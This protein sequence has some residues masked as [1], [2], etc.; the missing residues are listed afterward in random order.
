MRLLG[1]CLTLAALLICCPSTTA[2]TMSLPGEGIGGVL[3]PGFPPLEPFAAASTASLRVYRS[4]LG[5]RQLVLFVSGPVGACGADDEAM[6]T[7]QLE[8][9]A[10]G[11]TRRAD[12][13]VR[14]D[15]LDDSTHL[16]REARFTTTTPG[17]TDRGVLRAYVSR[18]CPSRVV[19]VTA[20]QR[21]GTADPAQDAELRAYLAAARPG[22]MPAVASGAVF[23]TGAVQVVVP[24]GM[25]RPMAQPS[26]PETGTLNFGTGDG[27]SVVLISVMED[28]TAM[29]RAM[30]ADVR[31]RALDQYQQGM[32]SVVQDARAEPARTEGGMM[33]REFSYRRALP[34][35]ATPMA[36]RTRLFSPLSGPTRVIGLT[37]AQL[38]GQPLNEARAKAFLESL[39]IDGS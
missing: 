20:L 36:M 28:T 22:A 32:L 4:Q 38:D 14:L 2:Q 35:A 7:A 34:G 29:A 30:G 9:L 24:A 21:G 11:F 27:A 39:T 13:P 6:R 33:I 1:G 25:G 23:R 5:S 17:R 31:R 15:S 10:G 19:A 3:P 8:L 37:Y 12:A 16:V 18:D 26:Q